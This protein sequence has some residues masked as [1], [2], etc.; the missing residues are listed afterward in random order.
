MP[1][2]FFLPIILAA[3]CVL[4]VFFWFRIIAGSALPAKIFF[5]NVGQ[6]DSEL[7]VLP[8]GATIMTDAG[9]DAAVL[10]ALAHAVPS[11]RSI[12]LAVITHPQLDHFNGYNFVLDH[13]HVGAFIYNGR[14]DPGVAEW[15]ELKAKIGER[16]IPFITLAAG[17]AIRCGDDT[18]SILSPGGIFR[19]SAE[20]ND[21]GLVE[22]FT[23]PH[24]R[25]LFA[26]DIGSAVERQL[27]VMIPDLHAAILK[28]AHHG[29]KY[30]SGA[31]F[32]AAVHPAAAVIEVGAKNT[33]GQ[34]DAGTLARIASSTGA[35]IFRTDRNGTVEVS[36]E[37]GSLEAVKER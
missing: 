23:M 12:D 24:F 30:A 16:H 17:D 37:D 2:R 11:L 5:L 18:V 7:A 3:V 1:L 22:M 25:A 8:G 27:L 35:E 14:D 21:T 10:A 4:D 20:L 32:L 28:V 19:S 34:P 31:A 15:A 36:Y 6:G 13:Y 9:P 33:Y 29:S 26:A